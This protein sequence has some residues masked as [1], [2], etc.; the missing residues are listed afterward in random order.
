MPKTHT[1]PPENLDLKEA[2]HHER[3]LFEKVDVPIV[4]VSATYRKELA[5]KYRSIVHTPSDVI[6]SRAHYSMAEAVRRQALSMGKTTHLSDPGNFVSFKYWKKLEF[7]QRLGR[8]IAR[9]KLLKDIKE[10]LSTLTRNKVPISEAIRQPLLYLTETMSCP[11]ISMHYETG[12]ILATAGKTVIQAVTDPHVHEQYLTAL[13]PKHMSVTNNYIS[14]AVFN[15]RTKSDLMKLSKSMNKDINEDDVVVT[16]P[17]VDPRI[18]STKPGKKLKEGQPINLAVTT[19]GLGT[20]LNEIKRVLHSFRPLLTPPEKIRLFL[21]AG[22]HKDF[23]DFFE[24]YAATNN[25]RIGNLD[26]EDARIRILYDD[27]IID[28]NENLIRYMFPWAHGVITK[29]SG[30]MAYD[31]A[32]AGCFILFLEP[33]GVWEKEVQSVFEKEGVGYDLNSTTAHDQFIKLVINNKL[34]KAL[35]CAH[36]LPPIY[37]E[38]CAN[39]INFQSTK[40]CLVHSKLTPGVR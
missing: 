30:D 2:L 27:S 18:S 33:W 19:G 31:A 13:P 36:N 1:P 28:A 38:G 3:H 5:K 7:T 35:D 40:P 37:R 10:R 22:N 26:D 14:F 6:Y 29:P 39:L 23:R 24:N 20:N 25:I 12:N 34:Q 4:T 8:L 9:H 16:G 15:E 32:A 11:V 17:F 21:Y